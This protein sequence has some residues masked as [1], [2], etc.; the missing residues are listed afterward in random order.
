[1]H[2]ITKL[3]KIAVASITVVLLLII[4]ILYQLP[5]EIE[6]QSTA[7]S[8]NDNEDVVDVRLSLTVWNYV[9]KPTQITGTIVFDGVRY[10]SMITLGYDVFESRNFF[11]KIQLKLNGA[12]YHLFVRE[13]NIGHQVNMLE[14]T[15]MISEITNS[16][17]TLFKSSE[18]GG[19]G[20]YMIVVK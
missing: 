18:D 3:S 13:D 14:D 17:I 10:E 5:R 1:M 15:I 16:G 2:R 12:T 20:T 6:I 11:E 8:Q 9:F 4:V 7:V 19:G